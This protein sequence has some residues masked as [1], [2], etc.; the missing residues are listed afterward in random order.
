MRAGLRPS[1]NQWA[2]IAADRYQALQIKPP[3]GL[4]WIPTRFFIEDL[5]EYLYH[6]DRMM[7]ALK[8]T[9]KLEHLVGLIVGG[10]NDM[11]ENG[12]GQDAS[13]DPMVSYPI[14]LQP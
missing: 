10:M 2:A 8:R 1:A 14:K 5:D 9:G 7:V 13:G 6:I 4:S 11:K 12:H 3:A